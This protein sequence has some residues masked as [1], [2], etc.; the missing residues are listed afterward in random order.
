MKKISTIVTLLALSTSL[1]GC[2]AAIGVAGVEGVSTATQERSAGARLDDNGIAIA[3]N[4]KF[5]RKDKDL[6]TGVATDVTEGRVL[7]TGKVANPTT[8]KDAEDL[9]WQVSGVREVIN[10]IKVTNEESFGNYISDAWISNQIRTRMLFTK[11]IKS[12]N[13]G[14]QTVDGVV[15]LMGIAQNEKEMKV[16]IEI[17]RRTKDVQRVVSHI[18]LKSDPRRP[19]A[20]NSNAAA[21]NST[22]SSS[23]SSSNYNSSLHSSESY[24]NDNN[25][26]NN[27]SN[28]DNTNNGQMPGRTDSLPN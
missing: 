22:S 25:D 14:V 26:D 1:T 15:Y 9:A 8:R 2:L 17:A 5:L 24:G 10:E 19:I 28:G 23:S 21:G 20:A 16:A 27:S 11:G 13:Y 7:L 18:I 12:N 6:F 4:D 3:I